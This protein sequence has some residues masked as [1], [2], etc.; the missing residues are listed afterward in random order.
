MRG[1]IYRYG[2]RRPASV[3]LLVG[4]ALA[5]ALAV[6]LATASSALA[7]STGVHTRS[8]VHVQSQVAAATH[9]PT[10]RLRPVVIARTA[11]HK[12]A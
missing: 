10:V 9:S 5:F 6:V 3:L 12:I 4:V 2:R 8:L 11:G 7:K 1:N